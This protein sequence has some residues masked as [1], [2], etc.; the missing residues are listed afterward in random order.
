MTIDDIMENW[1]KDSEIDRTNLGESSLGIAKLHHKYYSMY[2]GEKMRVRVLEYE[3]AELKLAKHEFYT[4][5]HTQETLSKGW[6]LPPK[7]MILK[8]DLP[9]YMDAD[10]D[11]MALSFKI[12]IQQEKI[13]ALDS[14]IKTFR[15]RGWNIRNFIE[16]EKF[17][18]G[19]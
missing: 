16:Y 1:S 14:I 18:A 2:V 3:Y 12:G 6:K 11:I 7:G 13:S 15:E 5:G 19:V 10:P 4:Q 8:S 17:R 9:M